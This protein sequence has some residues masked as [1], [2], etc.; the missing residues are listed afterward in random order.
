MSTIKKT[1]LT[2]EVSDRAF[3]ASYTGTFSKP[4]TKEQ[5]KHNERL[6][7]AL[8]YDDKLL[9]FM[10]NIVNPVV[11]YKRRQARKQAQGQSN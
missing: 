10:Y 9:E 5:Q 4:Q 2:I 1:V 3:N 6:I 7:K 8:I 11:R